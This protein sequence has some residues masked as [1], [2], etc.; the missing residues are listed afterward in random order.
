[1]QNKEIEFLRRLTPEVAMQNHILPL[2]EFGHT[3]GA[4]VMVLPLCSHSLAEVYEQRTDAAFPFDGATLVRWIGQIAVALKTVHTLP[5]KPGEPGKFS[6]RDLKMQNVLVKD[7][8][9][10]LSD[11]GIVKRIGHNLTFSLAGTPDWGAPEMLLPKKLDNGDPI[12]Q[13]DESADLYPLGLLIH[14]LVT[15][16]YTRA[17]GQVADQ[18]I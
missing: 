8:D 2:L 1:M 12:F 10:Y 9:L 3:D 7:N 11:Y 5:G 6:H 13:F 17:Q 15:G 14:A 18:I 4:P 16:N